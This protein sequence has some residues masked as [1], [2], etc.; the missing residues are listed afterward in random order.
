VLFKRAKLPLAVLSVPVVLP[1][2]GSSA[3]GCIVIRGVCEEGASTDGCVKR[4]FGVAPERK[5]ANRCVECAA[6][7]VK[8][9]ALPFGCVASRIASIRR[10]IERLRP[11]G[12]NKSHKRKRHENE[13]GP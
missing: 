2:K 1:K 5:Q 8:E 7:K 12:E 6:G 4:V 3:S 10:R 9:G 13:S 11:L